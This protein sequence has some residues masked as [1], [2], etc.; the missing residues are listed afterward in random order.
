VTPEIEATNER[1]DL[2][3]RFELLR[4]FRNGRFFIFSLVFRW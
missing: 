1:H 3:P 2:I 4:T